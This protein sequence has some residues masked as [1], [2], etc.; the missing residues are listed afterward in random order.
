MEQQWMM[1]KEVLF[2]Q[3]DAKIYISRRGM[4]LIP[5]KVLASIFAQFWCRSN[6]IPEGATQGE[7]EFWNPKLKWSVYTLHP[8]FLKYMLQ[9][10]L[11]LWVMIAFLLKNN[12]NTHLLNFVLICP[13]LSSILLFNNMDLFYVIRSAWTC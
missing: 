6:N 4:V 9:P 3:R 12:A 2:D 1:V 10:M 11:T 7:S 13:I 8:C 5:K